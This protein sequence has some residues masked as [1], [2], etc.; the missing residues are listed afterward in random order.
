MSESY[1]YK[2][3]SDYSFKLFIHKAMILLVASGGGGDGVVFGG[4]GSGLE[5]LE[6]KHMQFIRLELDLYVK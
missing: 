6:G 1:Y 2:I 4:L 5:T 3:C